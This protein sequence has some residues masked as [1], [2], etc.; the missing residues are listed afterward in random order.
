M[1]ENFCKTLQ[2]ELHLIN[3][4]ANVLESW[5]L[6]LD[7]IGLDKISNVLNTCSENLQIATE[8]LHKNYVKDLD[9]KLKES[10]EAMEKAF[11]TILNVPDE[12]N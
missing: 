8:N 5:S 10:Q 9:I 11:A 12:K 2:D 4:I 3:N 6:K 1:P 7:S